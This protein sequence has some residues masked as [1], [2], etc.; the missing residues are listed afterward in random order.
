MPMIK[1]RRKN[2]KKKHICLFSAEKPVVKVDQPIENV[3]SPGQ[4]TSKKTKNGRID[5]KTEL[6]ANE[7]RNSTE[8]SKQK[9]QSVPKSIQKDNKEKS[10]AEES[11]A[12]IKK[13]TSKSKTS[14]K[15]KERYELLLL[16]LKT[17]FK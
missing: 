12:D 11:K 4:T 7:K 6:Q 16:N 3:I 14:T 9:S 1:R 5:K 17:M 10:S 8:K 15:T 13:E 2:L